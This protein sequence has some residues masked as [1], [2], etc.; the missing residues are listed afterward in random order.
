MN[1]NLRFFV[2][3]G[4]TAWAC[5]AIADIYKCFDAGSGVTYQRAPCAKNGGEVLVRDRREKGKVDLAGNKAIDELAVRDL[6]GTWEA[7]YGGGLKDVWII[8]SDGW[9][10]HKS[11]KGT[12][13]RSRYSFS[14]GV[15]TVHH[16]PRFVNDYDEDI[17]LIRWGGTVMQ[18]RSMVGTTVTAHRR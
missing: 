10:I 5:P 12:T 4:L 1:L 11:Y 13:V 6:V 9:L 7:D 3:A 16:T 14:K 8:G 17:T 15:I 2:A 18:W